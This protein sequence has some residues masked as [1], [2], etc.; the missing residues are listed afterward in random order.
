MK[1]PNYLVHFVHWY[2]VLHTYFTHPKIPNNTSFGEN[3]YSTEGEEL[4]SETLLPGWQN[5][6]RIKLLN[7][8]SV[9]IKMRW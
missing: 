9:Q 5:I 8:F 7:G 2:R 1:I 6:S 4:M 3:L